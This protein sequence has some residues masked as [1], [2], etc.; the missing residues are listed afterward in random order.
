ME[1]MMLFGV[2]LTILP[3]VTLKKM[4][5]ETKI[6]KFFHIGSLVIGIICLVSSIML[7]IQFANSM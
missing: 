2:L 7:F 3:L 1:W 5:T 4:K 6:Q